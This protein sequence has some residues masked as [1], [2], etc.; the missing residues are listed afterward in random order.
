MDEQQ[1]SESLFMTADEVAQRY[2]ISVRQLQRLVSLGEM[3]QP[4]KFGGCLRWPI[5]ALEEFESDRINES[6]AVFN[7]T[8]RH[9]NT[10]RK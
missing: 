2:R 7:S 8:S 1:N 6:I 4:L 10:R 3:P 5:Q 9:K